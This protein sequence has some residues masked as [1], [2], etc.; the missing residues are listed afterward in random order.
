MKK[1]KST[2]TNHLNKT[3][4]H[5]AIQKDSKEVIELLINAGINVHVRDSISIVKIF[6]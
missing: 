5:Y 6:I 3:P 1:D 2:S 4:L